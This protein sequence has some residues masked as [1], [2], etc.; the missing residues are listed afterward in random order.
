M[1]NSIHNKSYK[2]LLAVILLFYS[3]IAMAASWTA[4]QGDVIEVT[5]ADMQGA[6][7]LRCFGRDWPVKP[8]VGGGVRGWIGVDLKKKTGHYPIVWQGAKK[9]TDDLQVKA[10]IFR[11]SRITVK[12]SMAQFDTKAVKRIRHDQQ[13][14]RQTYTMSVDA[15]PDIAMGGMPVEGI[16]S[17]PFGAQ[18][19]VNGTAKSPHSGLDIAAP[20]GTPLFAPLGGKVL[21][22][23]AMF[24]NGNT[25]VIGHGNG[26][27]SVYCHMNDFTVQQGEW[28]KAGQQIGTVGQTGR[29]TGPHV[30][31]GVHFGSAR[32]NP[33]S[34]LSK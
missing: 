30:H 13:L 34:L 4:I 6:V 33:M 28:I 31:W 29:S 25:V 18:R 15:N 27:V 2:L 14:L 24:L 11:I 9:H 20:K 17:T 12:K 5:I 26:L 8:M 1:N 23:E 16:I 7:T 21:L 19:Y 3:N 22:R 32:V 10:G